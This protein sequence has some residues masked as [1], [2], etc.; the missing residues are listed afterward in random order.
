MLSST[1]TTQLTVYPTCAL[2]AQLGQGERDWCPQRPR[3]SLTITTSLRVADTL[4]VVRDERS[5]Q[6]TRWR[7]PP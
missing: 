4:I 2:Q 1:T 5:G 6:A 3:D 7:R